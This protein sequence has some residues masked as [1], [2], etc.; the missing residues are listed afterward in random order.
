MSKG[1]VVGCSMFYL[2]FDGLEDLV[3]KS[4]TGPKITLES[5]GDTTSYGVTKGGKSVIQ[6]TV[7]GVSNGTITAVYIASVA[8]NRLL[9]WHQDSHREA[10]TGGGSKNKGVLKTGSIILYNQ[11][12]DEAARW[13][14]TGVM[15]IS[16]KSSKFDPSSKELATETVEFA[17]HSILRVK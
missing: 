1:E 8:D 4:C 10:I 15:P 11:A 14:M 3:L 7:T 12:G 16:Y 2:Q 5:A 9:L 13:N 6:A 17:Y